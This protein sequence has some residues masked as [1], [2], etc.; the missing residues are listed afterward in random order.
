MHTYMY[1]VWQWI[2]INHANIIT[3]GSNF[4]AN[5]TDSNESVLEVDVSA[6]EGEP[7]FLLEHAMS[8]DIE[9]KH[10][11]GVSKGS[12]LFNVI[13][14]FLDFIILYLQQQS[15]DHSTP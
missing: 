6:A 1:H 12:I 9:G 8:G 3:I 11:H 15:N 7:S 13:N 14:A 4:I 5:V 10:M 2:I